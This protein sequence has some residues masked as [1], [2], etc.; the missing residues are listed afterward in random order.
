MKRVG[1]YNQQMALKKANHEPGWND[2]MLH[3][4]FDFASI[5]EYYRLK[6]TINNGTL[7]V[8]TPTHNL[9]FNRN[10]ELTSI[11]QTYPKTFQNWYIKQE[12]FKT[13]VGTVTMDGFADIKPW[14]T[15]HCDTC[16]MYST[17]KI[18]IERKSIILVGETDEFSL[19]ISGKK[20]NVADVSDEKITEYIEVR[21]KMIVGGDPWEVL[22]TLGKSDI[23]DSRNKYE[24]IGNIY[25][26]CENMKKVNND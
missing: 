23:T 20:H 12:G 2:I 14:F 10:G 18:R 8:R 4:D 16:T 5:L 17:T 26:I 21:K 15:W 22:R 9:Q 3:Y 7:N 24:V 6:Y 13:S 19:T 11:F 1:K 25:V